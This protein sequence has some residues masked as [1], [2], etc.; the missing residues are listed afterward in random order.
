M[1]IKDGP[2]W[3]VFNQLQ[4]GRSNAITGEDITE[5][6]GLGDVRQTRIVIL[7]LI[8]AGVPVASA[9][10]KPLGYF[11]AVDEAEVREYKRKELSRLKSLAYRMR[12]FGKAA[13]TYVEPKQAV[14]PL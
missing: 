8:E 9:N 13:E 12:M 7:E 1:H 2:Q 11:I 4:T 3:D 5:L 6:T 10:T 14:M